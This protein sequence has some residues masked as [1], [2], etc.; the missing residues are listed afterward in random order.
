[1]SGV[2][3]IL[4]PAGVKPESRHCLLSPQWMIHPV[5]VLRMVSHCFLH[6]TRNRSQT[7]ARSRCEEAHCLREFSSVTLNNSGSQP[8]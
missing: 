6:L 3:Y 1:M 7:N 5:C 8:S 4:L 2:W